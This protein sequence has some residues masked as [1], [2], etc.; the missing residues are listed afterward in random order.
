MEKAN[1]AEITKS[2]SSEDLMFLCTTTL[3]SPPLLL[4]CNDLGLPPEEGE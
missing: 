1:A 4:L 2:S 3:H